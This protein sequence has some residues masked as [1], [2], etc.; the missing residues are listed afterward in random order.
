MP[1][2]EFEEMREEIRNTPDENKSSLINRAFE[3]LK[4]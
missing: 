1:I 2:E 4:K 3:I